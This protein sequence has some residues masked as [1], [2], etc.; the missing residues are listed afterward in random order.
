MDDNL[1]INLQ[2]SDVFST[3]LTILRLAGYSIF[4]LNQKEELLKITL[5][6][7]G[8]RFG[9]NLFQIIKMMMQFKSK[10]RCNF[11]DVLIRVKYI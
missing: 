1:E 6:E 2:K 3:G 5:E 11:S 4:E 7:F 10:D 9:D 8:N